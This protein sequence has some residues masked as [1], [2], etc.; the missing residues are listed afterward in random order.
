MRFP[1]IFILCALSDFCT[2]AQ[3][4]SPLIK[5]IGHAEKKNL[6][7]SLNTEISTGEFYRINEAEL[8]RITRERA[9]TLVLDIPATG[10]NRRLILRK[11]QP[12]AKDYLVTTSSGDT[13]HGNNMPIVHYRGYL[14]GEGR[15]LAAFSFS[16][17]HIFGMIMN[18][19]GNFVFGALKDRQDTYVLYN[20]R[21]M[22]I[23][24]PFTCTEI[25]QPSKSGSKRGSGLRSGDCKKV[26]IYFEVNNT[27]YSR[28]SSL[29]A[30]TNFVTSLFN[31][32]QA[33][34]E[35]DGMNIEI[36]GIKVW[37]TADP[38][39]DDASHS[40]VTSFADVLQNNFTGDVAHLLST[41][42]N[43]GGAAYLDVLC[44]GYQ[45][46][47]K[48]PYGYSGVYPYHSSLPT[49]SWSVNVV[50]H[51]LGHN[52][53][54]N[55]THY[56]GWELSPGVYGAIDSCFMVESVSGVCY[57]GSPVPR[58]GTI[59]SYCHMWGSVNLNLGFGPLPGARMRECIRNAECLT[60]SGRTTNLPVAGNNGPYCMG[61]TIF[62]QLS[63]YDESKPVSWSGPGGFRSTSPEPFF[64]A[65][66][67]GMSGA[68][69]V[70][71]ENDTCPLSA[72]T[73]ISVAAS[74]PIS[75][76]NVYSG[77]VLKPVLEGAQYSY[78][79]YKDNN[80]IPG[81]IH[82]SY[83]ATAAG[84]YSVQITNAGG[85]SAM[86]LPYKIVV[87]DIPEAKDRAFSVG[88]NNAGSKVIVQI[89]SGEC[90]GKLDFEIYEV[91][92]RLLLKTNL[93][94]HSDQHEIDVQQLTAGIYVACL[95]G[96]HGTGVQQKF[97]KP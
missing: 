82:V 75:A 30:T 90:N 93:P 69:T 24:N 54:S 17:Q 61:D 96:K 89:S 7:A 58:E 41:K 12:G 6:L 88:L 13:V 20:D 81:A 16:H 8:N 37:T 73:M 83:T 48:G 67:P 49:Y 59:M 36:S 65:A 63:N 50:T 21:D 70:V 74:P 14:Q 38:Y 34:Y 53:G 62:L 40:A 57:S 51:E 44:A 60:G 22:K 91:T 64:I 32:C 43:N 68:Y 27:M 77:N 79:W 4:S 47:G 26:K 94:C 31:V 42:A 84:D 18:D 55:H 80:L 28:F 11:S 66:N 72:S 56:C 52:F 39:D 87:S 15:S 97:F 46:P 9:S 3:H 86:S 71:V 35:A 19:E 2:Y 25:E 5:E 10:G 92:G 95:T 76:V 29:N 23:T 45:F 78:Q 33:I 85:C 1:I